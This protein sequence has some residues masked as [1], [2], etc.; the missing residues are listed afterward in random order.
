[1]THPTQIT[2]RLTLRFGVQPIQGEMAVDGRTP[3]CF[4]GWLELNDRI[5]RALS[6]IP[7]D[8]T[9]SRGERS[10]LR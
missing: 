4:H 7:H 10:H 8:G 2:V 6:P 5:E 3:G 1:M 9:E